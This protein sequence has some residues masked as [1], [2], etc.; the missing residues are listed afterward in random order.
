MY[1]AYYKP[2]TRNAFNKDILGLK[3][4]LISIFLAGIVPNTLKANNS[5]EKDENCWEKQ[6]IKTDRHRGDVTYAPP[7]HSSNMLYN[8]KIIKR[9]MEKGKKRYGEPKMQIRRE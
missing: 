7:A 1:K 8:M 9:V 6:K 2:E 3:K 5:R 4:L